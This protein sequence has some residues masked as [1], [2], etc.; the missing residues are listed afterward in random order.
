MNI[1]MLQFYDDPN[2]YS[3]EDFVLPEE[4][5]ER[6]KEYE[7]QGLQKQ[8]VNSLQK[9]SD[10]LQKQSDGLLK[11]PEGLQKQGAEGLQKP[12][13]SLQK[14]QGT[15]NRIVEMIRSNSAITSLQMA[16]ALGLSRQSVAK[17]LKRLQENNVVKRVGP[18]RGGHWEII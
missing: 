2:E 1:A 17:H 4:Y 15:A 18:D 12:S 9:Q 7:Q 14:E 3:V 10:S 13:E 11:E 16:E 5:E 8:D 6:K